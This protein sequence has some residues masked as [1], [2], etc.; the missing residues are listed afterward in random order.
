MSS[1]RVT[2]IIAI[3]VVAACQSLVAQSTASLRSVSASDL[4]ASTAAHETALQDTTLQTPEPQGDV[5]REAVLQDAVVPSPPITVG[6]DVGAPN[7]C[8]T[9][10]DPG[11]SCQAGEP[12]LCDR[13]HLLGDWMGL[14]SGLAEH[15]VVTDVI[16]T[17]FYQGV[18]SGG[19]EQRFRYG[20]KLD[21]FFTFL[22]EPLG[23]NKGFTL[24]MHAETGFGK[25]SNADAALLAPVNANMLTP[26]PFEDETAITGFQVMQALSEDWAVTAGRINT[27]DLFNTMYA[28]TGRGVDRFMNISSFFP[29]AASSTIPLVW[30]G[31]GVLKLHEGQIQ[32]GLLVLDN[33]NIPTVSGI[34]DLFAN[35]ATI[36]GLWRFF[37]DFGG[38]PGSSLFLGTYGT[39]TFN[40]L[41]PA[42]WSFVP[43]DGLVVPD[44]EGSW[45]VNYIGEQQLWADRCNPERQVG[46]FSQ[47]G[48]ADEET[49]PYAWCMN[50]SL[51]F[52]GA[53]KSRPQDRIG[54]AYFY[55]GL[56]SDL[57]TLSSTVAPLD[58]VQGG[59]VY[60]NAAITPWCYLTTDL[61]VIDPARER[62][63][64]AVLV[65]TRLSVSL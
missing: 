19:N 31:A 14:R 32:G 57:K 20:G 7:A 23:L 58:D 17:Q 59:E 5:L 6:C 37:T 39:G 27:F 46:L 43:G 22:G 28:Q 56:S 41:D 36:A 9:M 35:G 24:L 38:R 11:C 48:L 26:L 33:T 34:D 45:S 53:V 49:S 12:C 10:N 63:D 64:T 50:V 62:A 16:A 40:S 51:D 15:G 18:A 52:A 21:Y 47:W 2:A 29:M 55:N 8:D 54:A 13:D 4:T 44:A 3:V 42:G 25:S 30:N 60:Y 1:L 61:Q 65:G